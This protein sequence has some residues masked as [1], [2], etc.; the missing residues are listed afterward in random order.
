MI[1][2]KCKEK[3]Q[4]AICISCE[5]IQPPMQKD[6]YQIFG[7]ERRYF[8]SKEE[9]ESSYR[10]LSKKLHPD[11]WRSK[12]A[13]ERRMSQ[14]W[15]A[16]LNEGR[17]ILLD[18]ISRARFLASG[19]TK[20]DEKTRMSQDFLEKILSLQMQA[21]DAPQ[22]VATEAKRLQEQNTHRIEELFHSWEKDSSVALDEVEELLGRWK[23]LHTLLERLS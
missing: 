8:L 12:S 19:L 11:R 21:M 6:F 16:H 9:I 23:Y 22:E 20:T 15:T 4:G 2:W 17:K 18:P 10:S 5:T 3:T 13:L 1:C 7:L 14:Q